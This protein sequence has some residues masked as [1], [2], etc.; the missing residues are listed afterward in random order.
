MAA[1]IPS[2]DYSNWITPAEAAK[3][4]SVTPHQARHLARNAKL[5]AIKVGHAWLLDRAD[6][7]RYAAS[8]R[9]PGRHPSA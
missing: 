1:D 2:I 7:E 5:V 3:L 4:L 8:N 6:V 9:K